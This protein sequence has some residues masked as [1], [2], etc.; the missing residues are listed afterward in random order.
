M[1]NY[2]VP[3]GFCP[4]CAEPLET[5][6]IDNHLRSSCP[7]CSYIDWGSFSLGVGGILWNEG[8]VLLVQRAHNPGKGIWT[9]PGGY[10]NQGESIGDAIVREMQEETGIKAKPLSIIAL[11]DRPSNCSTEKHD[12]YIIFQMS[13][14]EG[15]L[16]A[17]PEEVSNL[18]FFTFEECRT[19]KIS[20]LTLS[21]IQAC[22]S[23]SQGLILN[24]D[25]DLIGRLSTLYQISSNWSI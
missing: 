24:K 13:L 22:R 25:A 18:G 2:T 8:K 19:L 1:S 15:T 4:V 10:V 3:Y 5:S 9:I 21:A 17:Q 6:T 20:S 23:I 14:L 16:H 7:N 11:R 12:T